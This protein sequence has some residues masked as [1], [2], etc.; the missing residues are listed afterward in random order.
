VGGVVISVLRALRLS[1]RLET[2]RSVC[3]RCGRQGPVVSVQT[4]QLTGMLI[5]FQVQAYA[6]LSCR[7]CG[8]ALCARTSL[9][10]GAL[11]W[12]SFI[13]ALLTPFV[14]AYNVAQAAW[15]LSLPPVAAQAKV[16]ARRDVLEEQREY[17]LNLLATKEPETVV[18]VLTR[19]TGAPVERVRAYV[20]A[21][22]STTSRAA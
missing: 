1:G 2:E 21:L 19:A 15:L 14:L 5:V 7:S 4:W 6:A 13:S 12:W 17:A 20:L 9:H 3:E 16:S 22:A 11:G 10:T 8:L 18:E